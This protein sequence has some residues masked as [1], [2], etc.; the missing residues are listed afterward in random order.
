MEPLHPLKLPWHHPQPLCGRHGVALAA[1]AA[2]GALL[3]TGVT[4]GMVGMVVQFV[5]VHQGLGVLQDLERMPMLMDMHMRLY[6]R[7]PT[8]LLF[9]ITLSHSKD[10]LSITWPL[11]RPPCPTCLNIHML[12]CLP[13]TILCLMNCVSKTI[14][15]LRTTIYQLKVQ[16]FSSLSLILK[17]IFIGQLSTKFGV[18]LNMEINVWMKR[19]VKGKQR[20]ALFYYSSQ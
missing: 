6:Q 9:F 19:I 10:R 11:N 14:I 4:L 3:L 18:L 17:M 12:R 1:L 8:Q 15:T 13:P 7:I 2:L 16:G 5:V 20:G